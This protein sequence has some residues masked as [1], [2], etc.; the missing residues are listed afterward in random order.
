MNGGA[1]LTTLLRRKVSKEPPLATG[2]P[3][4]GPPS[5]TTCS[6]GGFLLAQVQRCSDCN[7]RAHAVG[8]DINPRVG[9]ESGEERHVVRND[10]FLALRP[11]IVKAQDSIVVTLGTGVRIESAHV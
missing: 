11:V 4:S 8:L 2:V 3:S 9:R 6:S 10:I 5:R 7:E 1:E